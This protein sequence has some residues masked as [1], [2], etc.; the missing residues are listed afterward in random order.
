MWAGS[1]IT[2]AL[3]L[4]CLK[5]VRNKWGDALENWQST[6]DDTM[7]L[8]MLLGLMFH[9]PTRKVLWE[10][11]PLSRPIVY[12]SVMWKLHK[13]LDIFPDQFRSAPKFHGIILWPR[14]TWL[15]IPA[16]RQQQMTK[17]TKK[18]LQSFCLLGK[19]NYFF[20]SK[21]MVCGLQLLHKLKFRVCTLIS[22]SML[23][24]ATLACESCGHIVPV[25]IPQK[26]FSLL[27]I[28]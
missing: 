25:L 7:V 23:S 22:L 11:W 21:F 12:S 28:G 24:F 17:K 13:Y 15:C 19:R 6:R 9:N 26:I 3:N 5:Q 14:F 27:K 18:L 20:H 2:N 8:L 4:I 16:G 1:K 10:F